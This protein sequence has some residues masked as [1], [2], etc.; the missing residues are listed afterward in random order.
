MTI[1][2]YLIFLNRL[3]G[4]IKL[5]DLI[6]KGMSPARGRESG[7]VIPNGPARVASNAVPCTPDPRGHYWHTCQLQYKAAKMS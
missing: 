2:H 3:T 5:Y 7:Y 1:K 4:H 6:I